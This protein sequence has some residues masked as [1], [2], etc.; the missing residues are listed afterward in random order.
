MRRRKNPLIQSEDEAQRI[1]CEYLDL[2]R[3]IYCHVPNGGK[4]SKIEAAIF[5]GLG[6]KP[7]VPD[8]LIFDPPPRFPDY[9]GVALEL[10]REK[11]GR[12]SDEQAEWLE[13]LRLRGWM[14]EHHAGSNAAIDWLESLGF[15]PGK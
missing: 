1:V 6:V 7:G 13:K 12:L 3:A 15:G 11:G 8:L 4:R 10:K 14:A 9:V 2:C 5:K